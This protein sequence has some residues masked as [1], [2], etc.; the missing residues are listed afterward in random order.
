MT[1][2]LQ[3]AAG[4]H[5]FGVI[6]DDGYSVTAGTSLTDLA[7]LPLAFHNNGT[8]NETFEFVAPKAG[9]YPF[10]IV[11]YERGGAAEFE[12]FSV[13]RITGERLLINDPAVGSVKAF[14]SLA[15][16]PPVIQAYTSPNVGGAY[17]LDDSAIVDTAAHTV[18]LSADAAV[19]F[20][21]LRMSG[22]G[23]TAGI[24]ILSTAT[25]PGGK[26]VLTYALVI[27]L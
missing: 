21:R 8:A 1:A 20:V 13:N 22:P 25:A 26:L 18:T 6:S 9:L 19:K 5:Q 7:T 15:N 16:V 23:A 17:A 10:R 3:L 2:Y 12:I 14:R 27:T 24:A 11:W 4:A